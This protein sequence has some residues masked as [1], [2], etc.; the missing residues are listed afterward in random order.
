[1][2]VQ[3]GYKNPRPEVLFHHSTKPSLTGSKSRGGRTFNCQYPKGKSKKTLVRNTELPIYPT[4]Y[5]SDIVHEDSK[6]KAPNSQQPSTGL[7]K[8]NLS[9]PCLNSA[10]RLVKEMKQASKVAPSNALCSKLVDEGKVLQQVNFLYEERLYHD[11]VALN[12]SDTDVIEGSSSSRPTSKFRSREKDKEPQLFQF[13]T[14]SFSEEHQ[15]PLEPP[16]RLNRHA[17]LNHRVPV[18]QRMRCWSAMD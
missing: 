12:I 15:I 16:Q 5:K 13:F 8:T 14:P 18:Y 11:L 10:L 17:Y 6:D 7:Y 1:M 2:E 3:D 9:A 4:I